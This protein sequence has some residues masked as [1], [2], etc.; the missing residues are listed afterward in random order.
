MYHL[1]P[2]LSGGSVSP[3]QQCQADATAAGLANA[4]QFVAFI[5]T[6]AT[7]ALKRLNAN[8][9]PWKRVDEVFVVRQV[10]DFA[11]GRLLAPPGLVADGSLYR[12]GSI[13]SGAKGPT[14]P[15]TATC[16]DWTTGAKT[17]TTMVGNGDTTEAPGWFSCTTTPCDYTFNRLICIEP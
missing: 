14:S 9:A 15:A 11:S 8:R 16:R 13:W 7:P 12:S 1:N 2:F 6:A 4:P 10:S 3:D 5:S 17:L